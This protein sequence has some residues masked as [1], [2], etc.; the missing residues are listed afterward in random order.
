MA[1]ILL[2]EFA[3]DVLILTQIAYG[4]GLDIHRL[5]EASREAM[6]KA[7]GHGPRLF[8]RP[9]AEEAL[10][11]AHRILCRLPVSDRGN[12]RCDKEEPLWRKIE[13]P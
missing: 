6:A 9:S 11:T 8:V 2:R 1:E 5:E 12:E 13:R 10:L 4:R 7:G 3:P